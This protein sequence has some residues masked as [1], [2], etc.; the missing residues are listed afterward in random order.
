MF[1]RGKNSRKGSRHN[2]SA[3]GLDSL[4]PIFRSDTLYLDDRIVVFSNPDTVLAE[5]FRFLRSKVVH[6]EGGVTPRTI[7]VTSAVEKEGKTFIVGNL[8]A[9]LCQG[10]D[11]YVLL[12]DADLRNPSIHTLYHGIQHDTGLATHLE[13][14][15][16]LNELLQKTPIEKL[17]ILPGGDYATKP[18]E[19]LSSE[20]MRSFIREVRNRYPD[21]FVIFDSS[22]LELAPEASII[23]KEVDAVL[24]VVHYGK[25]P[26]QLVESALAKLPREKLL[27]VVF[28]GYGKH[29]EQYNKYRAKYGY[30]YGT[31]DRSSGPRRS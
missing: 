19:L 30:V 15:T 23:A 16:P 5:Q 7:L 25:T 12:V 9:A 28:N 6:P 18:L 14:S 1:A 26:R 29:L 21:R 20:K 2:G 22:P 13:Q 31:Y 10:I 17:T 8:A 27:G 24:M 4:V 11:E 3:K